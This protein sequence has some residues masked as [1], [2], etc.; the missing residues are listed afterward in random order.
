M[1]EEIWLSQEAHDRLQDELETLKGEGRENVSKE[2][3]EAR[4]HGDLKENA[5]YHAAKDKQGHMEARIRQLEHLMRNAKIGEPDSTDE[6]KQGLVVV[7]DIE[8]DEETYLVGSR[9]DEHEQFEIL[10]ASSPMGEAILGAKAGDTVTANAP[11]GSFEITV[12]EIR[13]P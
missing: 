13:T 7:L 9:E 5:E 8:G 1:T 4:A 11:A 10:S 6:V 2:I 12:K 3:E